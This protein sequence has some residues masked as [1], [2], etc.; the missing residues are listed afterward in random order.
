MLYPTGGFDQ[1]L[2]AVTASG[3][4]FDSSGYVLTGT[5]DVLTV[6]FVPVPEPATVLAVGAAGLGALGLVRRLRRRK[7]ESAVAEEHVAGCGP[8]GF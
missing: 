6:S 1:N 3:F 2:F 5:P 4:T 8:V 7:S